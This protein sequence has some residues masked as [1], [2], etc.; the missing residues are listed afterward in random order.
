MRPVFDYRTTNTQ[1]YNSFKS[2][3]KGLAKKIKDRKTWESILRDLNFG[4][5]LIML[6]HGCFIKLPYGFGKVGITKYKKKMTRID[7]NGEQKIILPIDWKKTAEMG[8]TI[9]HTNLHTDGHKCSLYWDQ[10]NSRFPL[11]KFFKIEGVRKLNRHM[12]AYLLE[13]NESNRI[14]K[15]I[16]NPFVAWRTKLAEQEDEDNNNDNG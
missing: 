11:S 2:E 15:Y 1:A 5:Y 4:H 12:A 14:D 7:E 3:H 9:Y 10:A 16:Y 6:E 13:P 8:K